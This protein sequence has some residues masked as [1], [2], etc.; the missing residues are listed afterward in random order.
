V[1]GSSF[2]NEKNLLTLKPNE[3]FAFS[4][5]IFN[6]MLFIFSVVS[7]SYKVTTI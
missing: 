5:N 4:K 3:D 7:E 2:L 6:I 1:N